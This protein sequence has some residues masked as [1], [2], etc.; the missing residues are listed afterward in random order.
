MTTRTRRE[1]LYSSA[2]LG[3][4]ALLVG[5]SP[6]AQP[7]P[8]SMPTKV[9][10]TQV[11]QADTATVAPAPS[12]A[13]ATTAPTDTSVPAS[14]APTKAVVTATA[15][16]AEAAYLAVT[17][18]T[19]P[20]DITMRAI[21][22]IGG[23]ERFVKR[24]FNVIVKPNICNANNGPEYAS[25]T[26]PEVVATLIKL[27]LGAGAKSVR[28][29]DYPFSGSAQAAY[30]R[31]GIG[32]AVKAAG[33]EMELMAPMKFTDT[34]IP[35]GVSFKSWPI[36]QPILEADLVINVPIA[37][38]HGTTRLT[39]AAKNLMGVIENR[40]TLHRDLGEGIPDIA[41]VVKP[42]LTVID[43]V[44]ILMANGPTGGNLKD[45]KQTN[46]IIASH[47]M[48]AADAY[49]TSLF[50]LQ[51]DDIAYITASAKRGLGTQDLKSIKIAELNI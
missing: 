3:L 12:K 28:V 46:T 2:T 44:R 5:C 20:Q 43:A 51:P 4:G 35:N 31:S 11:A 26:N 42:Q 50:G 47:D 45:V 40:G 16:P 27:C 29:M 22:A 19:S 14:P 13:S 41:S 18:G 8:T 38:N 6:K 49:A 37:K 32:E 1:F 10:P 23:I 33:G 48:V 25:T 15:V 34:K 36:Y 30:V 24:G 7:A 39:L 9:N 17:H 21:A